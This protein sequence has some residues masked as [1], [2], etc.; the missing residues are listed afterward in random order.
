M[1]SAVRVHVDALTAPVNPVIDNQFMN[2]SAM[3]ALRVFLVMIF[4]GALLGQI[5]VVPTVASDSAAIYPEVAFLATPYALVAIV[6]IACLQ[7]V[8]FASWILL[9]RVQN[10]SIFSGGVFGWV[11][12]I[13]W[14]AA[15]ATMLVLLLGMHLLGVMKLGG[16][17]VLLAVGGVTVC[18]TAFVLLMV[19]MRTLLR[20]ATTMEKELAEALQ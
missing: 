18:G 20:N 6:A 10:N 5:A 9:A 11:N 12:V 15:A 7:V 17:G 4:L 13:I 1:E 2:E 8:L 14:S 16:P 19:V 3:I